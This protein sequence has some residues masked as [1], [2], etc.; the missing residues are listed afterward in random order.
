M[1]ISSGKQQS[2][3]PAIKT[4]S[5]SKTYG[6][7]ERSLIQVFHQLRGKHSKHTQMFKALQN[8]SFELMAG[9][10]LGIIGLNGSGKSTLLQIIGGTLAPS[11]G[12]I[13]ING[14]VAAL[15]ELGSG[16]NPD[17]TGRENVQLNAMLWGLTPK[18]VKAKMEEIVAYADIGDFVDQPVRTYS[19]GM[20]MR[21]AFAVVAHVKPDILLVDEA[22]AVGDFLFQLKCLR[23]MKRLQEEGCSF[24][25]VSHSMDM[26]M[27]FCENVLFL[28]NGHIH[29]YG[30]AKEGIELYEKHVLDARYRVQIKESRQ[31]TEADDDTVRTMNDALTSDLESNGA[32][33]LNCKLLDISGE[34]KE[35]FKTGETIRVTIDILF[36]S[37]CKDPHCG[38]KLKDSTGRIA[39]G[40]NTYSL[41]K[42][43][44][45]VQ[46]GDALAYTFDIKQHLA[47]GKYTV[48]FGMASGG[49]GYPRVQFENALFYKH[50]AM[51]FTVLRNREQG[52]WSG[53]VYIPTQVNC[54]P[55]QTN[56]E[57]KEATTH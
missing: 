24:L 23:T 15:L 49:F 51:V 9:C 43:N 11:S 40:I 13:E 22:L 6:N 25:F 20:T 12:Q 5:L 54:K 57:R 53:P 18:E 31:E 4:R 55:L 27:E 39:F 3:T 45:P 14:K 32:D 28:N 44:G 41:G 35:L 46:A 56:R 33:L 19:T 50:D 48:N 16:F 34:T 30:P 37:E 2:I 26:I 36:T 21:L 10:S 1:K 17:F 29:F 38:V 42:K 8:I 52:E 47:P 7:G